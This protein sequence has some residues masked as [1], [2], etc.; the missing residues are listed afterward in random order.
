MSPEQKVMRLGLD[1]PP[2]PRAAGN[3]VPGV[4]VGNLLFL[5]GQ[6]GIVPG[7]MTLKPGGMPAEARQALK[8]IHAV[9]AASQPT[10]GSSERAS[11]QTALRFDRFLSRKNRERQS[12]STHDPKEAP[13]LAEPEIQQR[14]AGR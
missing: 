10:K 3:Y 11:R 13:S 4:Q 7:T 1:L 5:S 9:L 12:L 14:A 2:S 6:L 8:N